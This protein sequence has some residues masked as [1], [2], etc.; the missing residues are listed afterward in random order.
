MSH[1]RLNR[2]RYGEVEAKRSES[3][4]MASKSFIFPA[5]FAQQRL[6]FLDQLD[7][8]QS[9]YNMVYAV[10]FSASIDLT[11]LEQS[12]NEI[13]GRHESLR[14]T[15]TAIDGQPMQVIQ[16]HRDFT[17]PLVDL[18]RLPPAERHVESRL[19]AEQIAEQ[20]FDL[21]QGPLLRLTLMRLAEQENVLL[22]VMHH[23]VSDGWSMGIFLRE[24]AALYE[25]FSADAP[26]PLPELP[27]QYADYASW[28]REWLQGDV[29]EE[30]LSY[31]RAHLSGA[32]PALELAADRPR[33]SI[34]TFKGARRYTNLPASLMDR[35]RELSRAEGVTLFMTMLAAF[36]VLL[37]RYSGQDDLTVGTPIAGRNRS[38]LES[39]IGFFANTLPLRANLG[40]NPSFRALLGRVREIALEAYAHQDV[41]FDRLVDELRPERS[42]AHTPLFQVIFAFENTPQPFEFPGLNMK[43]LE[44]DRGTSRCDLSLFATDKG[45]ELSCMWEYSTDLFDSETIDQMMSSYRTLLESIL[46]NRTE[47]IGYLQIWT[48]DQRRQLIEQSTRPLIDSEKFEAA[49]AAPTA[50]CMQHLF[51]AQAER[52]PDLVAMVSGAQS[53]TYRELNVR[54]NRLAHHLKKLGVGSEVPV[55]VCLERSTELVVAL[56]AVLKAGGAYVP[57]DPA[58]PAE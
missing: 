41:P 31:W 37:W 12:L 1:P 17:L 58:Y 42:L 30:Q 19:C 40:D 24:L 52:T 11:V 38:E 45:A 9:V 47:K 4:M 10:R 15:F 28:Q 16:S 26:S 51:E 18:S 44:V 7:P 5:S 27:I 55:G 25:A 39:L 34:Q 54:G 20:P 22:V 50:L 3:K 57:V 49:S 43:W 36:D 29:M 48:A 14:T 13:V 2:G 33:P 46:D 8:S 6:W 32:P 56:L 23:S 35:L 53:L 21:A